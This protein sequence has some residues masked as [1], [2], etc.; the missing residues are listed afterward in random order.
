MNE[1]TNDYR[2]MLF[3]LLDEN[4]EFLI[5]GGFAVS[6]H[7]R[8]RATE[9][10]DIWVRPSP[11][12]VAKL[13]RGLLRFRAPLADVKPED[14]L[15]PDLVFQIGRPPQRIDL[16]TDV[17]GLD[18]ESAWRRRVHNEVDGRAIP[19]ISLPDL[20]ANKAASGRSQDLADL[21]WF[22][23]MLARQKKNQQGNT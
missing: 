10:I 16:I 18:F 5:V 22:Q 7:G 14:F 8:A 6:H 2:D 1:L 9:D 11:D 20:L 15:S 4:V 13:W 12:N 3:A 17:D 19:V 23:R 21:D